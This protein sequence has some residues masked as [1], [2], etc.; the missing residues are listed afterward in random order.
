MDAMAEFAIASNPNVVGRL[1]L[2]PTAREEIFAY[3]RM[4][5]PIGYANALRALLQ[6]DYITDQLPA[7]TAPTLLVCGDRDTSLGPMRVMTQKVPHARFVLLSPAGHLGNRDQPEAFNRSVLEFLAEL[8]IG[9]SSER[10]SR[11]PQEDTCSRVAICSRLRP[12]VPPS[13]PFPARPG[14]RRR[15]SPR[16]PSP[17]PSCP[18]TINRTAPVRPQRLDPRADGRGA[19]DPQPADH[20]AETPPRRVVEEPEPEHV[21]DQA[22]ARREVSQRRGVHRGQRQVHR[23]ARHIGRSSIRCPS[24]RGRRPSART[25]SSSIPT[26]C[27]SSP[28]SRTRWCP[29]GSPRS[30]CAWRRPRASAEYKDKFVPD[31]Y[32]GTGPFRLAEYVVGDRV[33]VEAN[34]SYWGP[35]PPSQRIVWQ[36]IPDAA[37]RLAALQRG[38]VDVMLNLPFPLAPNVEGDPSLRLYSEL[39]SLTLVF[40]FNARESAPLKDR[41][42][43]QAL[44]MAVDRQAIIK[45]LYS[46]RGQSPEYGHGQGR[47][48]YDGSGTVSV[49]S[50][51]GQGAPGGG[52]PPQRL[53]VHTVAGGR[54]VGA[55]EETA[56]VIAGYWGKI[57][58]KTKVQVLEW[59]EYNKR[60]AAG[61]FKDGFYYAFINGTWDA[62]YT[63]QRFKPDF[64]TF[65]Y[66]DASGDLLKA[67]QE[68]ERTSIPSGARS[69][70]PRP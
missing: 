52:R 45:N 33:A 49:R 1:K 10:P 53:R 38:D 57:G 69:W 64:Q 3:Y 27:A 66:F 4:L 67:I 37:T 30:P 22:P 43:R 13:P 34:P 20:G 56:Q 19:P 58:V 44:N 18:E 41:R 60:S 15:R 8:R 5:T 59:A 28:R 16:S 31:R 25:S 50:G 6:M 23:R 63:V 46:G 24:S 70:A 42:V 51:A 7:I 35:K 26:P 68:Y 39:G 40:C 17:S 48:R 21:G 62:S 11:D 29:A 32:I 54:A 47:R 65:R 61:A 2:D 12:P 36:V 9:G 14:P 55:A